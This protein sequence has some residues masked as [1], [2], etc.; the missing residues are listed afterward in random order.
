MNSHDAE[1][2]PLST[3]L[4]PLVNKEDR[5]QT[6]AKVIGEQAFRKLLDAFPGLSWDNRLL[7]IVSILR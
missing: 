4:F 3:F 1:G 7:I 6:Y 2:P 5:Y